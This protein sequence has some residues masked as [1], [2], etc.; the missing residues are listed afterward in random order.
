MLSNI[1]TDQLSVEEEVR[2]EFANIN[3]THEEQI[4][5]ENQE[6]LTTRQIKD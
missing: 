2:K 1:L 6:F 3:Y 4:K 5:T